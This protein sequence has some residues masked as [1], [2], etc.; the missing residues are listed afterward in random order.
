MPSRNRRVTR[1][2]VA[3]L[4]TWFCEM[5]HR[6]GRDRDTNQGGHCRSARHQHP[7]GCVSPTDGYARR[8]RGGTPPHRSEALTGFVLVGSDDYGCSARRH[9]AGPLSVLANVIRAGLWC[10]RRI[11]SERWLFAAKLGG[12]QLSIDEFV[13]FWFKTS[14]NH[15][16]RARSEPHKIEDQLRHLLL[17]VVVTQLRP[18]GGPKGLRIR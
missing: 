16:L 11:T 7:R 13:I 5:Y 1:V 17:R 2:S 6:V 12:R 15:E 4:E 18:F 10:W 3:G 9:R 14:S 8:R